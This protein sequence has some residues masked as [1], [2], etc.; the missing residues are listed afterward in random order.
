MKYRFK[1]KDGSMGYRNGS[2]YRG[3]LVYTS[4]GLLF[5]PSLINPIR[6]PKVVIPYTNEAKFFENWEIE[7]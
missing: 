7:R 5:I 1:G 6:L 2:I 4:D 3:T